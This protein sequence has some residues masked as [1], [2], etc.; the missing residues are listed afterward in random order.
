M[1]PP[2]YRKIY[3]DMIALKYP[4]KKEICREILSKADLTG[5]DIIKL[6][7]LIFGST[8]KSSF[9]SNQKHRS[10]D[11]SSILE[12]L[13]FQKKNGHSNTYVAKH[14]KLSRNTI[15]KWKKKY[16]LSQNLTDFT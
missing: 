9:L 8:S 7:H 1:T 15:A 10:Y 2:D 14:F 5:L 13:A 11:E 16:A 6:N 12:I 3:Q 4:E